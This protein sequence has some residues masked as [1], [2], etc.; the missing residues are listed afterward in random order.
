M[1]VDDA[2]GMLTEELGRYPTPAQ[3][4]ERIGATTEE[5]LES[6]EASHARRTLSLDAPRLND[7]ESAPTIETIGSSEPGF[8]RVESALASHD[9]DLSERE[10]KVLRM[11]FVEE[12]TQQEIGRRLGVSQ[13]QIS[14]ISRR[15]LWKLLSAVRGEGAADDPV[16]VSSQRP[17]A[18]AAA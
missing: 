3:V 14:R 13:M 6:L 8:E 15:A 7:E 18:R 9:A 4:A 11:R 10:W 16:P 17:R 5:V 2:V 12:L 1:K